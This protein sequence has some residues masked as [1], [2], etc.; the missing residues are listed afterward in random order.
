MDQNRSF[1][2]RV[3]LNAQCRHSL[4]LICGDGYSVHGDG[5]EGVQ[6]LSPCRPLFTNPFLHSA[7]GSIW[8]ASTDF[9]PGLDLL[10]TGVCFSFLF[11]IFYFWLHVLD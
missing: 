7:F 8:T 1:L 5:W 6:F 2:S 3:V 10:G 9:E 11:H 4:A